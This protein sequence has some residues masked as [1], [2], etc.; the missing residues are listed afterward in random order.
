[1]GRQRPRWSVSSFGRKLP[2]SSRKGKRNNPDIL[3]LSLEKQ[4]GIVCCLIRGQFSFGA[5]FLGECVSFSGR[6]RFALAVSSCGDSLRLQEVS[7]PRQLSFQLNR[8]TA[9]FFCFDAF[10]SREPQSVHGSSPRTCF[11]RKRY[12]SDVVGRTPADDGSG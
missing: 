3:P 11:A 12:R 4:Q 1:M 6:A 8:Q 2:I 5:D 9:Q 10:S 7:G